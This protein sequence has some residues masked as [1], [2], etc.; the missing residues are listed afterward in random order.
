MR[1]RMKH[2]VDECGIG[3]IKKKENRMK[4]KRIII[5]EFEEK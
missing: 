1:K 2:G 3:T 4:K 5:E